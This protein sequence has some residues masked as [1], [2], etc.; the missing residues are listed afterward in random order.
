MN[1]TLYDFTV[2]VFIKSLGGLKTVLA[3]AKD[4]GLDEAA[5]LAD[6][7]A[8]DMFPFVKQVQ[9]AC[10]NAKGAAARLA[11][12]DVPKFE[13]TEATVDELLGRID[14]TLAFVESVE[15]SAF[16]GAAERTISLPFW[17]GKHMKGYDYARYY[18][19]PNFFFHVTTAYG[20][21]RKNSVTIGKADYINGLP[22]QEPA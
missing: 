20:L 14:K 10:D 1:D 16:D 6:R 19:L 4:H 8:P 5:L 18:A 13:D 2:P 7:L 9:I 22:L 11:G 3:K 15:K 21:V 12:I 17:N